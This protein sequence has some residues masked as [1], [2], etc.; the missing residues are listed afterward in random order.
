MV[1]AHVYPAIVIAL[2]LMSL[3][4]VSPAAEGPSADEVKAEAKATMTQGIEWLTMARSRPRS[5]WSRP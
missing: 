2:V 3:P 5:T 1:K 4:V